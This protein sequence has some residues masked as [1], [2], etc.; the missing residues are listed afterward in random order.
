[1]GGETRLSQMLKVC[2][3]LL[4]QNK[5]AVQPQVVVNGVMPDGFGIPCGGI[6][7]RCL[8]IRFLTEDVG[9]PSAPDVS[10]APHK[11]LEPLIL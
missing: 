5:V 10:Q 8:N 11:K 6:K 7:G 3:R 9:K 1:M 4:V 2:N